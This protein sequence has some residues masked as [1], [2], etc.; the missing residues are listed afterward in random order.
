MA[1][2]ERMD[3]RLWRWAQ[4]VTVGDGSGYSS[5]SPLHPNWSPPTPGMRPTLKVSGASSDAAAT[6]A[7]VRELSLRLRNTVVVHY[8]L[9][10]PIAEQAG[11]LE[12]AESTVHQRIDEAHRRLA[13]LL[14]PGVAAG[15]NGGGK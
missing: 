9:R 15:A 13:A 5:V 7:A 12:C 10:L 1:R 11:R 6:H 3:A 4:A 8:C 14:A 2:D